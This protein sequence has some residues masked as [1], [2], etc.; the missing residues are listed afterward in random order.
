MKDGQAE[1]ALHGMP[2]QLQSKVV[3]ATQFDL[4]I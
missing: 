2:A 4:S 3:P 1:L